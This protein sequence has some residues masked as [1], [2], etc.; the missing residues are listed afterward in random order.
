M[1]G[2]YLHI[3]FCKQ[4]CYY[5]NFHFSTSLLQQEAMVNSIVQEI[6]LQKD[7][8]AQE[9]VH[10]IYF[11]GGTPSL[12]KE[13]ELTALLLHLRA[14]FAVAADAEITLEANPDDLTAEKLVQLKA[15]G[16]NRL[17]IGVQSFHEED[18]T[19]MNR[20]HNSRQALD[21]IKQA[22]DLGFQNITI[23]LIYGGPTLTNEGW[24]QNVKQ[25]IALGV[26]HLSC[27]ALT[28]EPGTALDHFIKKKKMAA[29]DPDKAAQ[30]FE[31][32]MEWL[33]AAG[34]EHYE[35]SNFALPGWH[36]R[37]NSSYWQGKPYLGLGPSAHSFN[38]ISRQWN[39]AN[40]AQY[41]KSIAAGT[42]PF[43]IESLTTAMQFNEYIM[44]SLRTSAGCNL[45]WVAEK[46]GTDHTIHLLAHSEPYIKM[47]R[48]ERVGEALRLTKAGRLFADGIA[49]ELFIL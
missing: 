43:E 16:I 17:S 27:Y 15:A 3:P 1:A 45:E 36:S 19:W 25:A 32:L 30:H 39:I 11:G 38:G 37:H 42:V 41:I 40:N 6:A 13:Q 5:C 49:G 9:P 23:D 4:A 29:T 7:Y 21:C 35:I 18:L 28:V 31:M 24:E 44:T 2:I 8:L 34:Y 20:A 48:M 46:F 26:P 14:T 10:T 47:G 22:Q 33:G 12:L